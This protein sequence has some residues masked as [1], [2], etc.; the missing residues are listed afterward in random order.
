MGGDKEPEKG[1]PLLFAHHWDAWYSKS[2]HEINYVYGT[3]SKY[4]KLTGRSCMLLPVNCEGTK[5][6]LIL[7]YVLQD[8]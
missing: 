8:M 2:I 1:S 3:S 4:N 5:L 7:S 6:P